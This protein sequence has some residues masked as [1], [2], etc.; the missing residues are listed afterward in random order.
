M[1]LPCSSLQGA[2]SLFTKVNVLQSRLIL[3]IFLIFYNLEPRMLLQNF[4]IMDVYG[5][6]Q[7][8]S[9][10]KYLYGFWSVCSNQHHIYY[11]NILVYVWNWYLNI[12]QNLHCSPSTTYGV[13]IPVV[14]GRAKRKPL[15]LSLYLENNKAHHSILVEWQILMLPP[16]WKL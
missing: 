10:S 2:L 3:G 11:P 9:V 1:N 13:I 15:E 14:V 12:I 8:N 6:S 7:N 4:S 16:N 5:V